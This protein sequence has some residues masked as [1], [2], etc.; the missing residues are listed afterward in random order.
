MSS[1]LTVGIT[2]LADFD[3]FTFLLSISNVA[4]GTHHYIHYI[5]VLKAKYNLNTI[6]DNHVVNHGRVQSFTV[7]L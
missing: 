3:P 1:Y 4:P 5:R 7:V 6:Y 2:V